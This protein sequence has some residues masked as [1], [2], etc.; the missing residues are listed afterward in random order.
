MSLPRG[1]LPA[2]ARYRH[3]AGNPRKHGLFCTSPVERRLASVACLWSVGGV[4]VEC[5]VGPP[6]TEKAT[7]TAVEISR[8]AHKTLQ[9]ATVGRF[10]RR[11]VSRAVATTW[12]PR[13][14]PGRKSIQMGP[15]LGPIHVRYV[16]RTGRPKWT[17][18]LGKG[19]T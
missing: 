19:A 4:L 2:I 15:G 8:V 10:E 5:R 6:A 12:G 13:S 16:R 17:V 7:A 3:N 18:N 9:E 1:I 14:R 11:A